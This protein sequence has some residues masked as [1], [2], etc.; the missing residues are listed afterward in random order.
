MTHPF[1]VDSSMSLQHHKQ[2]QCFAQKAGLPQG[3]LV[4]QKRRPPPTPVPTAKRPAQGGCC[5]GNLKPTCCQSP[6]KYAQL[7]ISVIH[8][9]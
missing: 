3:I 8:H 6:I 5:E 1:K 7:I 2:P 4:R 9:V